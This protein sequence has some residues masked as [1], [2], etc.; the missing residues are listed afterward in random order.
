MLG[1][2]KD[3]TNVAQL[4]TEELSFTIKMYLIYNDSATIKQ[5]IQ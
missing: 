1:Q 5:I 4:V 3:K 2:T